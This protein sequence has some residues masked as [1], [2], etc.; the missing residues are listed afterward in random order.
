[1]KLFNSLSREIEEFKPYDENLV[2]VYTC[3]P[4]VYNFAHIGNLRCYIMEDVLIRTLYYNGYNV[5]RVMNVTDVGHLSGDSDDGED[6]MLKGAKR[7][8]K[9]VLEIAN[10]YKNAFFADL[11]K[12]NIVRPDV[13]ENATDCIENFIAAIKILL[14][15]GYAYIAGG[16]VYFDTSKLEKYHV[17]FNFKQEDLEIAVRDDVSLDEFK[18]HPNDFVLWFTKS[19]FENQA[20]KWSSPW[21]EGYPGWHIECSCIAIKHLGEHVDIHCGGIGNAFPHHTNEIAQSEAILGHEWCKCWMHVLH[22]Q[23]K[24]GKMS[25]SKG[26][27]LTLEVAKNKGVDPIAYRYFCLESH[28]RKPLIYSD[29]IMQNASNSYK[30]LRTKTTKL[31]Q[32]G[33]LNE[34]MFEKYKEKFLKEINNDLNTAMG[35]SVLHELLKDKEV[36]DYT[37]YKLVEDFDKVLALDL[38]KSFEEKVD[39]DENFIAEIEE[40]I[41]ERKEAKANKNYVL[42][43]EIRGYLLS[44]GVKLIDTPNGTTFEKV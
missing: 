18:R 35:I 26:E 31:S 5:K 38:L 21:G 32:N 41:K 12:L 8:N 29:E 25:K 15:K 3:G 28:Y 44:K 27:F 9:T 37:K 6:K 13:I 7:E 11:E 16:N 1:M 43:D 42:A 40:K 22:L 39:F 10:F 23:T 33:V 36:D 20:L 30:K 4:T 24:D 19:K 2:R 14:E 34:K 17:F